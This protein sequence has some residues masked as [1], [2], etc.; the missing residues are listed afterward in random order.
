[1]SEQQPTTD[2]PAAENEHIAAG[3]ADCRSDYVNP[4]N[5]RTRERSAA[6]DRIQAIR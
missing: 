3:V 2:Q 5:Q 6:G 1:M 4:A